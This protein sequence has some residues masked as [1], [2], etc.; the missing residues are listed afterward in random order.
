M[1]R[2]MVEFQKYESSLGERLPSALKGKLLLRP[3]RLSSQNSQ[4]LG[5]WL[6][7]S[8]TEA[9]VKAALARLDTESDLL[10]LQHHGST[11]L[12]GSKMQLA[13]YDWEEFEVPAI[14]AG[15]IEFPEATGGTW[16]QS[17][18]DAYWYDNNSLSGLDSYY[19]DEAYDVGLD[20]DDEQCVWVF[21]Q[22]LDA[23]FD[24]ETLEE[25]FASFAAVHRA[26][27]E[28][29]TQRGWPGSKG[30]DKNKGKGKGLSK[31]GSF[32][33]KGLSKSSKDKGKG[34]SKGALPMWSGAR[35]SR[36]LRRQQ[37]GMQRVPKEA[38]MSKTRCWRCG[39]LG[40]MSRNC[41]ARVGSSSS[42]AVPASSSSGT[43]KPSF[44]MHAF[45][46][47][48]VQPGIEPH[49]QHQYAVV[50]EFTSFLVVPS[51]IA[52]V[53]TGAVNAVCGES[54]FLALDR[55]LAS[56]NLGTV[57][58]EPPKS[59]GGIGGGVQASLGCLVPIALGRLPGVISVIVIP[60][61]VPLLLPSPLLK[62][63]Q[64]VVHYP[65]EYVYWGEDHLSELVC[66]ESG[67]VGCNIL[68]GLEEF[69]QVFPDAARFRRSEHHDSHVIALRNKMH[70]KSKA[71]HATQTVQFFDLEAAPVRTSTEDTTDNTD[72][73]HGLSAVGNRSMLSTATSEDSAITRPGLRRQLRDD[74]TQGS[75]TVMD[76]N[77]AQTRPCPGSGSTSGSVG[78]VEGSSRRA[79]GGLSSSCS[80][81]SSHSGISSRSAGP[82]TSPRFQGLAECGRSSA[83]QSPATSTQ[84]ESGSSVVPVQDLCSKISS[85]AGGTH[86]LMFEAD[87]DCPI[88]AQDWALLRNSCLQ[89]AKEQPS[90]LRKS[91]PSTQLQLPW[92]TEAECHESGFTGWARCIGYAAEGQEIDQW[93]DLHNP[94]LLPESWQGV[95]LL[96]AISAVRD[97]TFY[98]S[99]AIHD[100]QAKE[101]SEWTFQ[102]IQQCA[103]GQHW[104]GELCCCHVFAP[105]STLPPLNMEITATTPPYR[106]IVGLRRPGPLVWSVQT[107][108][109]LTLGRRKRSHTE[110]YV[111]LCCVYVYTSDLAKQVTA[112]LQAIL[113]RLGQSWLSSSLLSTWCLPG[114]SSHYVVQCNNLTRMPARDKQIL[115]YYGVFTLE[116]LAQLAP[117]FIWFTPSVPAVWLKHVPSAASC[118]VRR[119]DRL[120]W[121]I[122]CPAWLLGIVAPER[123][124]ATAEVTVTELTLAHNI[125]ITT[126]PSLELDQEPVEMLVDTASE[127][128]SLQQACQR[129][130]Q[131][132]SQV[133]LPVGRPHLQ[134]DHTN[135]LRTVTLGAVTQRGGHVSGATDLPWASEVLNVV[136]QMAKLRPAHLQYPYLAVTL[137]EGAV[138]LHVD[139]NSGIGCVCALG[140]YRG[141]GELVISDKNWNCKHR[142]V[143]FDAGTPHEVKP[144]CNGRRISVALYC[145]GSCHL[146]TGE[147]LRRLRQLGF[148]VDWWQEQARWR[149]IEPF[150]ATVIWSAL[151]ENDMLA[152][153]EQTEAE[154]VLLDEGT[155]T[156]QQCG[157]CA[158]TTGQVACADPSCASQLCKTCAK[159]SHF[160]EMCT[161][162]WW[163]LQEHFPLE[164]IPEDADV[165]E[166]H[167]PVELSTEPDPV[168]D[169]ELE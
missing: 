3:A 134:Q 61:E 140:D 100:D 135:A 60:G 71:K 156:P 141:G 63:L 12:T 97:V 4:K 148:P 7:G 16:L 78:R 92:R 57:P 101:I 23:E 64:A 116:A 165:E 13:Q 149:E 120:E 49:A 56:F 146:L 151:E 69:D 22:D 164:M 107:E 39:Q 157:Q 40:H 160:C 108:Q 34:K 17:H 35:E 87:D 132:L 28:L 25:Q 70:V 27:R 167:A 118:A 58:V 6:N 109:W 110:V 77:H 41:S 85:Q 86:W 72:L 114:V 52:L 98:E 14:D 136:H 131:L 73:G 1:E 144:W 105:T 76:E 113:C 123:D 130:W 115:L 43:S 50:S 36:D 33:P 67:H 88:T 142:W 42:P 111:A 143:A 44:F 122:C 161:E 32:G 80:K 106:V 145:P 104:R 24:E 45:M 155:V 75:N 91:T 154:V 59:L 79:A 19:M 153:K 126:R 138:S 96:Q 38:L 102:M 26:K 112:T 83:M 46:E 169:I 18:S 103:D 65:D 62:A 84:R 48:K 168:Q 30:K 94:G 117:P 152:V 95:L 82:T 68:D 54:Q 166:A 47:D 163:C 158:R 10:M 137:T 89:L 53:D 74:S 150:C 125:W 5:I 51:N 11:E 90:Y 31:G 129:C 139:Q 133:T 29:R 162:R 147:H 128:N 99:M 15:E 119:A 9:D 37:F 127:L 20:S 8:R 55:T 21:A 159:V 124:S 81:H 121:A 2:K 66:L 93:L